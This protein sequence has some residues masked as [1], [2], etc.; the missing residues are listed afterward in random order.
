MSPPVTRSFRMPSEWPSDLNISPTMT[1]HSWRLGES[2]R[3]GSDCGCTMSISM[4][5]RDPR[6]GY[7]VAIISKPDIVPPK[8]SR[9]FRTCPP[10]FTD[11]WNV[12]ATLSLQTDHA[13]F[14]SRHFYHGIASYLTV[15]WTADVSRQRKHPHRIL[16]SRVK[17]NHTCLPPTSSS[18]MKPSMGM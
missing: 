16:H 2:E 14:P 8:V 7:M 4:V 10:S 13:C 1:P 11:P 15:G 6:F 3:V 17:K 18:T 5:A 9:S 12:Y